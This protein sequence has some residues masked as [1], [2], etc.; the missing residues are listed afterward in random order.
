[1]ESTNLMNPDDLELP[2]SDDA[3]AKIQAV[4][5]EEVEPSLKIYAANVLLGVIPAAQLSESVGVQFELRGYHIKD[6]K[7]R[8]NRT[9]KYTTLFGFNHSSPCAFASSSEK[10][11]NA[12]NCITAIYGTPDKWKKP[13]W[14]KIR[15]STYGENGKAYGLEVI[16]RLNSDD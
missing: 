11:Y 1:M 15:M 12:I 5:A 9:G 10:I 13:I 16:G 14:V 6:V 4:F 7:Y 2:F 8:D 3:L